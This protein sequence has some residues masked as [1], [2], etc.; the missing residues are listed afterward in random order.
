VRATLNSGVS[1][2]ELQKQT[3]FMVCLQEH[4]RGKACFFGPWLL[5]IRKTN[6]G[7]ELE[8]SLMPELII[9]LLFGQGWNMAK[10]SGR[11]SD[12]ELK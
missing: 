5:R 10:G 6:F 2:S 8:A 12:W 7:T 11:D 9:H 4:V 3:I 1:A